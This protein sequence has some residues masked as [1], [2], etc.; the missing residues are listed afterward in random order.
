MS[1]KWDLDKGGTLQ[2]GFNVNQDDV[3]KIFIVDSLTSD[4]NTNPN[5]L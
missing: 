4:S 5:V 1:Y 2:A 3:I